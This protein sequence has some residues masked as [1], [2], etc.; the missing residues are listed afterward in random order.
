[1]NTTM[2]SGSFEIEAWL[3][4]VFS[5]ERVMLWPSDEWFKNE[6]NKVEK[7]GSDVW[8]QFARLKPLWR[9]AILQFLNFKNPQEGG[10]WSLFSI[11]L[12]QRSS[13]TRLFGHKSADQIIQLIVFN[14]KDISND[15]DSLRAN[16][17][18]ATIDSPSIRPKPPERA[19]VT[20]GQA[21]EPSYN[22]TY[23]DIQDEI[24]R[25]EAE[26]NVLVSERNDAKGARGRSNMTEEIVIP[27]DS[28]NRPIEVVETSRIPTPPYEEEVIYRRD[29]DVYRR[30]RDA[31]PP[32]HGGIASGIKW[33]YRRPESTVRF[34]E[35]QTG[36]EGPSSREKSRNGEDLVIRSYGH[37]AEG[38]IVG[39]DREQER[40]NDPSSPQQRQIIIR[41]SER[42]NAQ[43]KGKESWLPPIPEKFSTRVREISSSPEPSHGE[44]SERERGQRR[45]SYTTDRLRSERLE[46][47]D[48]NSSNQE[49]A[50]VRRRGGSRRVD[51][52][53]K[54]R[55]LD[56]SIRV[57]GE[58]YPSSS[59]GSYG[60]GKEHGHGHQKYSGRPVYVKAHRKHLSPDT[61]DAYQLPWEWDEASPPAC[62]LP[63]IK[64]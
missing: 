21:E 45:R 1:M 40:W 12:P 58:D 9:T 59:F 2:D 5:H 43:K 63:V 3:V 16:L 56:R 7:R 51:D 61:L 24:R 19:F 32:Q 28:K 6:W 48:V 44:I 26:R 57:R 47:A 8:R 46:S 20:R 13:R 62:F 30:D 10:H 27:R 4:D 31:S 60:G 49:L 15:D 18:S 14:R 42:E 39:S 64:S 37:T 29:R 38:H 41:R 36:P 34:D 33:I 52:Y 54:D 17:K 55:V 35:D 53:I 22:R 23:A 25:L 50:L 11:E